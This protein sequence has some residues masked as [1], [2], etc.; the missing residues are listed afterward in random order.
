LCFHINC[1]LH[2]EW[3]VNLSP[4]SSERSADFE[5]LENDTE[6]IED[7]SNKGNSD[8]DV[9][10][11]SSGNEKCDEIDNENV[12]DIPTFYFIFIFIIRII[13]IFT[14]IIS[15]ISFFITIFSTVSCVFLTLTFIIFATSYIFIC[16]LLP[17]L[18][19]HRLLSVNFSHFN[20][21]L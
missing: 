13:F 4:V 18:G 17:S 6:N 3:D 1:K 2:P 21:L 16:E 9:G 12:K 19:V 7:N 8:Y 14:F 15:V 11:D 5:Q 20:L 10:S